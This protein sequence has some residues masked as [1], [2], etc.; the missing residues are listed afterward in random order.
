MHFICW[1]YWSEEHSLSKRERGGERKREREREKQKTLRLINAPGLALG[2]GLAWEVLDQ[3]P[4][5]GR[6]GLPQGGPLSSALRFYPQK[7][8]WHH[9]WFLSRNRF[10]SLHLG[11]RSEAFLKTFCPGLQMERQHCIPPEKVI[12]LCSYSVFCAL[13]SLGPLEARSCSP[14]V[15]PQ[16]G[17]ESSVYRR[18]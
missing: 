14:S 12:A 7:S 15:S 2:L 4:R 18:V 13:Q 3:E 1:T 6:R 9:L 16:I 8:P 11:V 17:D 5:S 10:P